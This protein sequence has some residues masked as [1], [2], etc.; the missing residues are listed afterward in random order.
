ME[1]TVEMIAEQV[2]ALHA[3]FMAVAKDLTERKAR[4]QA[5]R[6]ARE[7]EAAAKLTTTNSNEE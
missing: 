3:Q 6:R 2:E 1:A 4:R 5:R 7:V